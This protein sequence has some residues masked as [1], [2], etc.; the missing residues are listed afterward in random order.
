MI[1]LGTRWQPVSL[2]V[3]H[4]GSFKYLGVTFDVDKSSKIYQTIYKDLIQ[5]VKNTCGVIVGWKCSPTYKILAAQLST[6]VSVK[7]GA[8]LGDSV[9]Q[10]NLPR[11]YDP[12]TYEPLL[13][14]Y[15]L[16]G[17]SDSQ[18]KRRLGV[19]VE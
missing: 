6:L 15:T 4:K 17:R 13:H 19:P 18:E 1:H 10:V 9:S 5:K 7:Y 3:K 16:F 12:Y 8:R 11:G 14:W 2:L